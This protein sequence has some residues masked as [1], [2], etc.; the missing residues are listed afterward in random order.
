[1][2]A[3]SSRKASRA[4]S[5]RNFTCRITPHRG[6]CH[7]QSRAPLVSAA[8]IIASPCARRHPSAVIS[9]CRTSMVSQKAILEQYA[10]PRSLVS[11]RRSTRFARSRAPQRDA[12]ASSLSAAIRTFAT[13]NAAM[14]DRRRHEGEGS[15]STTRRPTERTSF[16]SSG[17]TSPSWQSALLVSPSASLHLRRPGWHY[18][19]LSPRADRVPHERLAPGLARGC[20]CGSRRMCGWRRARKCSPR[21]AFMVRTAAGPRW[22]GR[23]RADRRGARQVGRQARQD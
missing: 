16:T 17:S 12:F 2:T 7:F 1:M 14:R 21:E 8:S 22:H 3:G 10:G 6:E 13:D 19:Q 23:Q 20:S 4:C 9:P 11:P 5:S 15:G 18:S